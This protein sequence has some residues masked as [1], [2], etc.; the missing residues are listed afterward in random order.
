MLGKLLKHEFKATARYFIPLMIAVL[1]MTPITKI[2]VNMDLFDGMLAAIPITFIT[3]YVV[4]LFAVAVVTMVVIIV[5]FYQNMVTSQG[6][7]MHTLPVSSSQHIMSKML[8]AVVWTIISTII[9]I[10]SLLVFFFFPERMDLLQEGW[11][12]LMILFR[13]EVGMKEGLLILQLGLTAVIGLF[14]NILYIYVSIAIGQLISKHRILGGIVTAFVINVIT[15]ILSLLIIVPLG[16]MSV[17]INDPN[18]IVN[19]V[20]PSSILLSLI[21]SII[22]FF[23]TSYILKKK[24]NLE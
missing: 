5:R 4:I 10:L 24:L 19:W 11:Q 20:L 16:I 1:I 3:G 13:E 17:D 22:F 12:E 8:V 9:I 23:G 18:I 7:L 6:Y 14:Y 21:L 2:I 15:Q